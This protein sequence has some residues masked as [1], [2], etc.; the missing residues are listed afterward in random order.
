MKHYNFSP[1]VARMD[2]CMENKFWRTMIL[3]SDFYAEF[4]KYLRKPKRHCRKKTFARGWEAW[5]ELHAE[6][7]GFELKYTAGQKRFHPLYLEKEDEVKSLGGKIVVDLT[8]ITLEYGEEWRHNGDAH[9]PE[10]YFGW[11]VESLAEFVREI[12]KEERRRQ[13]NKEALKRA[14][15][16]GNEQIDALCTTGR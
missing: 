11:D 12:E 2:V 6:I 15:Q 5:H 14:F 9:S 1:I 3:S 10:K 8:G 7:T 4:K 13:K 16:M